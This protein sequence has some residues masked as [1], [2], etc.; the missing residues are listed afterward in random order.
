MEASQGE[1]E[2]IW[3]EESSQEASH[4]TE[5]QQVKVCRLGDIPGENVFLLSPSNKYADQSVHRGNETVL[6]STQSTCMFKLIDKEK[7]TILG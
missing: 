7:I 6:F 2:T 1:I 5:C 4:R 3:R